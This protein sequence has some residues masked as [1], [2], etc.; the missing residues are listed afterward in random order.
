MTL[1]TYTSGPELPMDPCALTHHPAP[2]YQG[3]QGPPFHTGIKDAIT[4]THWLE[5]PII[6]ENVCGLDTGLQIQGPGFLSAAV[7]LL[8]SAYTSSPCP[9]SLSFPSA[10]DTS[11]LEYHLGIPASDYDFDVTDHRLLDDEWLNGDSS[12]SHSLLYQAA[13]MQDEYPVASSSTVTLDSPPPLLTARLEPIYESNEDSPPPAKHSKCACR[14]Q[15]MALPTDHWDEEDLVDIYG[16]GAEN[17]DD[18]FICMC[19]YVHTPFS[20]PT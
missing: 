3:E 15:I 13:E 4:L 14:N 16:S 5:L 12:A 2:I 18:S 7:R 20:L 17:D 8:P 6:C 10:H 1:V 19:S 11:P 9:P